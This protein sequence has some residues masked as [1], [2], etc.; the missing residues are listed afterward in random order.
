MRCAQTYER[1]D[2]CDDD[3]CDGARLYWELIFKGHWYA[4]DKQTEPY[5]TYASGNRSEFFLYGHLS[6]LSASIPSHTPIIP[7]VMQDN[8]A[9]N[10]RGVNMP[11][12]IWNAMV[13]TSEAK[14]IAKE[15]EERVFIPPPP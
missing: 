3:Y 8:K 4:W 15:I 13:A 14:A 6:F 10:H 9:M 12:N 5:K 1:N 11:N 7:N 2:V